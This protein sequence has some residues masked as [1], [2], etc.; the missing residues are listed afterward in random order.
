MKQKKQWGRLIHNTAENQS[1]TGFDTKI[2]KDNCRDNIKSKSL[3]YFQFRSKRLETNFWDC[4]VFPKSQVIEVECVLT[5]LQRSCF[6]STGSFCPFSWWT[7]NDL[8]HK[9]KPRPADIFPVLPADLKRL[10]FFCIHSPL[11]MLTHDC[12]TERKC[13]IRLLV[14]GHWC[15][16]QIFFFQRQYDAVDHNVF[17]ESWILGGYLGRL[18]SD[19]S[20]WNTIIYE[21]LSL[22]PGQLKEVLLF[23]VPWGQVQPSFQFTSTHKGHL[24]HNDGISFYADDTP[25]HLWEPANN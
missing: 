3:Q 23:W 6:V 2:V 12:M 20:P 19:S 13:R 14:F 5:S 4:D 8:A 25:V 16:Q 9:W 10:S 22:I 17:W 1:T 21:L 7:S 15:R 18:L 24:I 11:K